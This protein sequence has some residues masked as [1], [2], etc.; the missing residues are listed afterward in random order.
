MYTSFQIDF[1]FYLNDYLT[2]QQLIRCNKAC[3]LS[4]ATLYK[5][6]TL[7]H[8]SLSPLLN[9]HL[10]TEFYEP[11]TESSFSFWHSVPPFFATTVKKKK[12]YFECGNQFMSSICSMCF[13]F[14][15]R[16]GEIG[17]QQKKYI[18]Y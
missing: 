4:F 12:K 16:T 3:I 10:L 1:F 15:N 8:L 17:L 7:K 6:R 14:R 5:G 18:V 2:C 13:F 11:F 9:Q